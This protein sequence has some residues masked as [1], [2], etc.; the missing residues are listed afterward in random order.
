M[1]ATGKQ[2]E[3]LNI[4]LEDLLEGHA[5]SETKLKEVLG[6]TPIQVGIPSFC[7][8]HLSVRCLLLGGLPQQDCTHSTVFHKACL[9]LV[10]WVPC[11]C[12]LEHC[13]VFLSAGSSPPL[14]WLP[15]CDLLSACYIMPISQH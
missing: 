3:V 11:R 6:H 8:T 13:L 5:V 7:H 12:V 1:A 2:A 9:L 15:Y 10:T 14:P 4:L